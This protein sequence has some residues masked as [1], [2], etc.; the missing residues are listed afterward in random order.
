MTD[1]DYALFDST[2]SAVAFAEEYT[3]RPKI[4]SQMAGIM[5]VTRKRSGM[6]PQDWLNVALTITNAVC[7]CRQPM[8]TVYRVLYGGRCVGRD[9]DA[10]QDMA[11]HLAP[12]STKRLEQ[13]FGLCGAVLRDERLKIHKSNS[14]EGYRLTLEQMARLS[15]VSRQQF[16]TSKQWPVLLR[17][18]RLLMYAWHDQA[19][20]EISDRLGELGMFG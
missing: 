17:E 9:V 8:A 5:S 16:V 11:S 12:R 6:S 10:A 3:A 15:G 18:A 7:D 19:E 1:D 2:A 4:R 20:R 13:V 14:T